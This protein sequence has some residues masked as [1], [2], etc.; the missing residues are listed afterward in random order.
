MATTSPRLGIAHVTV[1][2]GGADTDA[3]DG[4]DAFDADGDTDADESPG[5]ESG[6]P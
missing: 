3:S 2:P 5:S 6:A 1:V 4:D